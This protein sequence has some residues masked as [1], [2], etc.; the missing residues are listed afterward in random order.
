MSRIFDF[1]SEKW[2]KSNTGKIYQDAIDVYYK[3]LENKK[4]GKTKIDKQFEYNT[5]IRAFF[6]DNKGLKLED[7][8][9]CWHYKKGLPGHNA[10]EKSDLEILKS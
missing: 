8:I 4:K 2:L 7:A 10:Y 3:I 5:Y 9:R 1:Q 6:A